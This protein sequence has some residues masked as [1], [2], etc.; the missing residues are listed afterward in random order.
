MSTY[1]PI[2]TER[3]TVPLN[4]GRSFALLAHSITD[5]AI[6]TLDAQGYIHSWNPGA[7]KMLGYSA[8][9]VLGQHFSCFYSGDYTPVDSDDFVAG[10]T[11][12]SS[13]EFDDAV[14]GGKDRNAK[15]AVGDKQSKARL[16]TVL[17]RAVKQG[18]DEA[19]V[20]CVRKDKSRFQARAVM[21]VLDTHASTDPAFLLV[22]QNLSESMT[23]Q[24]A[25]HESE[26]R[27]RILVEGVRDYAIYMLDPDGN[28]TNWNSGAALI[29]GYTKD[30]IIGVYEDGT[31]EF[32][33][34][35]GNGTPDY[36]DSSI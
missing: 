5:Y 8:A 6:C 10:R 24:Q 1:D 30:E 29:K 13:F 9:E 4:D 28:I 23:V 36:L 26:E 16:Q 21:S 18:T 2:S 20:W 34:R 17:L 3:A 31:L 27:F 25:L 35:N 32:P 14:T 19:Y 11:K 7:E 12:Q 15:A 33:D 22:I